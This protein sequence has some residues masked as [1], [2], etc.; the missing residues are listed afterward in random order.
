MEDITLPVEM[1]SILLYIVIKLVKIKMLSM[2][3]VVAKLFAAVNH[4]S[5]TFYRSGIL[6]SLLLLYL[7][8][9][10]SKASLKVT[11]VLIVLLPKD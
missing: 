11:R 5:I 9:L 8:S 3:K 4:N 7:V 10:F 2:M 1:N 6:N